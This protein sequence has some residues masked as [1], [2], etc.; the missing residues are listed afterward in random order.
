EQARNRT[1]AAVERTVPLQFLA[2]SLVV[3]WYRLHGDGQAD[4]SARRRDQPWYR[5]KTDPAF[6]DM[7]AALRRAVIEHRISC[8]VSDLGMVR[9]I[10]EIVWDQL[11]MA[12]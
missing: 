1:R 2:Y 4:V 5:S 10:R 6:A 11:D 8:R 7:I 9:L 12:A 3:V